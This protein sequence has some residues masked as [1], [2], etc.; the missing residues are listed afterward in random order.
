MPLPPSSV[1]ASDPLI[2]EAAHWCM[3]MHADD[4][5]PQECEAF[6]RWLH[7]DPRHAEEYAAMLDIWQISEHLP[8]H[9]ARPASP[10]T[11]R[12][13]RPALASAAVLCLAVSSWFGWQQGW[14]PN[15]VQR[16]QAD[17]QSRQVILGDGSQIRLNRGTTLWF[18][19]FRD[20]RSIT[21]REG[22]AFFDVQH[23]AD[24]PFVVHAGAGSVTVTGTRFNVWKYLDQVVVTLS[25]GSVRVQSPADRPDQTA[26]LTPGLQARYDANGELPQIDA[27]SSSALAWLDGK[28]ILDNLTLAEALPQINR[29]LDKPVLLAGRA[30]AEMRI[31][32][33]Y[34]TN[35]IAGLVR[36]LPTVLPITL[37]RNEAGNTVIRR[38]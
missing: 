23:D 19:N 13:A 5:T 11:R 9:H 12:I 7:S 32:G 34:N 17:T 30:V 22:E 2:D 15:D 1:P 14:V 3:R 36:M 26:Y 4:R 8:R 28:L 16:F 27:A 21:L 33:I 18:A 29:Y 24:H 10:P 20:Q 25:E 38:R 6:E 31:G 35:D 37:A